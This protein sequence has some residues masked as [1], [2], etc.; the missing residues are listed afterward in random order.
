[1]CSGA[2]IANIPMLI[3]AQNACW[4]ATWGSV[5]ASLL[6]QNADQVNFARTTLHRRLPSKNVALLVNSIFIFGY[7]VQII[8]NT[9]LMAFQGRSMS[10]GFSHLLSSRQAVQALE[11]EWTT[12]HQ[13]RVTDDWFV[14]LQAFRLYF[15]RAGVEIK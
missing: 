2:W 3:M 5:C 9:V 15:I 6:S 10:L 7:V 14:P 13:F 8:V 4:T 1:M 11:A 12:G